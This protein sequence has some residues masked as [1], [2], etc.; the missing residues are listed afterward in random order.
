MIDIDKLEQTDKKYKTSLSA[1]HISKKT[2]LKN[3][4]SGMIMK[5]AMI[6]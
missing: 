4:K 5:G 3:V 6:P 1:I 2:I